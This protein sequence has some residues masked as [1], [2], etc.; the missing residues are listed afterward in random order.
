MNYLLMKGFVVHT[1]IKNGSFEQVTFCEQ[2]TFNVTFS[3]L[4]SAKSKSQASLA[5]GFMINEQ[6]ITL[7]RIQLVNE[8]GVTRLLKVDRIESV[9]WTTVELSDYSNQYKVV[10]H[11]RLALSIEGTTEHFTENLWKS[12]YRLPRSSI[13]DRTN[14]VIP[15]K[16][17]PAFTHVISQALELSADSRDQKDLTRAG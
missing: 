14:W 13:L 10:G 11:I 2:V 15:T 3:Y 9:Q 17:G 6:T 7:D 16:D 5:A 1:M 8:Q 12:S 4:V